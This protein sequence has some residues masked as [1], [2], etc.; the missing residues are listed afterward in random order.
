LF[1]AIV[2]TAPDAR[3]QVTTTATIRG[4]V[5][6]ATGAVLPGATIT[7]TDAGTANTRTTV[8]DARGQ[9]LLAGVFP[10][11]YALKVEMDGFK[12]YER[13]GV[14]LSPN[15]NRGIDIRLEVGART[16]LVTVTAVQEV[17]QT[18][19]GAREG[20]LTTKQIDNLS[21]IGRS[22]LELLRIL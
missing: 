13:K 18:E 19:T 21:I 10:G 14:A 8:S 12:T 5:Q 16:E 17:T 9:Y 6:D 20:V 2:G 3:A 4:T 1:A 11:T 7:L 22:S 15:D